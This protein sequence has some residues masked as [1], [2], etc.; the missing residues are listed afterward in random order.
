MITVGR[1]QP[2][3]RKLTSSRRRSCI[4]RSVAP[5]QVDAGGLL[6]CAPSSTGNQASF[7]G[8]L[9][10]FRASMPAFR[11]GLSPKR[12]ARP[13]RT[14]EWASQSKEADSGR[15]PPLARDLLIEANFSQS[16]SNRSRNKGAAPSF[17]R[18]MTMSVPVTLA[19][20]APKTRVW[21]TEE[22][23]ELG[24]LVA[25]GLYAREVAR[26]LGRSQE[27]VRN[28]ANRLGL[29]LRSAPMR[30]PLELDQYS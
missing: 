11:I 21:T 29:Q 1:L 4:V 23:A 6:R 5:P 27:A 13:C 25:K 10:A 8:Q 28:R 24:A 15:L 20:P 2:A 7:S 3:P 17:R 30:R 9:R 12:S 19:P 18:E 26:T 16:G 22:E 14:T